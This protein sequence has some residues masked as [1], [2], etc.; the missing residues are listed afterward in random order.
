MVG[1]LLRNVVAAVAPVVWTGAFDASTNR[2][3]ERTEMTHVDETN[4]VEAHRRNPGGSLVNVLTVAA[5]VAV[6]ALG[7]IVNT[8]SAAAIQYT[9]TWN[10]VD[11][12]YGST[13]FTDETITLTFNYDTSNVSARQISGQTWYQASFVNGAGISVTLG[14]GGSILNDAALDATAQNNAGLLS[15]GSAIYFGRTDGSNYFGDRGFL[16]A[17]ASP[18]TAADWLTT[19]WNSTSTG[20]SISQNWGPTTQTPNPGFPLVISGLELILTPNQSTNGGSWG[21]TLTPPTA[22]PG[23]GLAG[24]ATLGLAG[25]ARRRRR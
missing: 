10:Q 4:A 24:L 8:A 16:N 3:E 5:S 18:A 9:M 11:G 23:A 7:S 12:S 19:E 13:Q 22:V 6:P 20:G 14:S 21:S 15:T 25:V 17:F 2:Q 1:D